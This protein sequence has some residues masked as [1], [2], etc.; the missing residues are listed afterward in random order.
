MPV[1]CR[2]LLIAYILIS[3]IAGDF[4]IKKQAD[5]LIELDRIATEA[6]KLAEL[7]QKQAEENKSLA[8]RHGSDIKWQ[9]LLDSNKH[10]AFPAQDEQAA[11]ACRFKSD[12]LQR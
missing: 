3:A 8:F 7:N 6:K 10:R 12:Q 9:K 5:L 11:V 2:F 4:A 1:L